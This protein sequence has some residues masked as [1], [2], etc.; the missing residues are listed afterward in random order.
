MSMGWDNISELRP[1]GLLFIPQ[2]IYAHGEPWW[3]DTDKGNLS[4]SHLSTTT[5]NELTQVRTRASEV[6]SRRLTARTMVR[7]D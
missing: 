2:I 7:P 5:P 4:K 1:R 3:N 6:R